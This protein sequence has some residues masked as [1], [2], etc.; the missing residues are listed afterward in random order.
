MSDTFITLVLVVCD[1][2][3]TNLLLLRLGDNDSDCA[4]IK[5]EESRGKHHYVSFDEVTRPFGMSLYQCSVLYCVSQNKEQMSLC[6]ENWWIKTVHS[7][8][9]VHVIRKNTNEALIIQCP[10]Y[11]R[12]LGPRVVSVV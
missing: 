5:Q 9:V 7:S 4:L 11:S 3:Q 1:I 10:A 6:D 2:E 12:K 8:P